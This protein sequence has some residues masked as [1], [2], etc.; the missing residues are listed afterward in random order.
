MNE[1][2]TIY[3][4]GTKVIIH[5]GNISGIVQD[6]YIGYDHV[7]YGIAVAIDKEIVTYYKAE[8]EFSIIKG[9]R[10]IKIGFKTDGDTNS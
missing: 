6:I 8:K 2:F 9:S 5:V 1:S 7:R 3:K 4:P 10:K